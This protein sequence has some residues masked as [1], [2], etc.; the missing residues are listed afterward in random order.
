MAVP[1]VPDMDLAEKVPLAPETTH[2]SPTAVAPIIVAQLSMWSTELFACGKDFPSTFDAM[3]CPH[4]QLSRQ[5][6]TYMT[7]SNTIHWPACLVTFGADVLSVALF[8]VGGF[9]RWAF[10]YVVRNRLRQRYNIVG[11]E[12]TDIFATGC[13]SCCSIAQNH[14]EMSVRGEWPAG[15]CCVEQPFSL[16]PPGVPVMGAQE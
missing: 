4:C 7:G 16:A 6:N 11:D 1:I 14:R 5:Y 2:T 10:A 15:S 12:L 9:A 13:C 3:F 8:G